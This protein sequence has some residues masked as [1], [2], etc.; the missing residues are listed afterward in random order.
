MHVI[1]LSRPS[2]MN[3]N[4]IKVASAATKWSDRD[5]EASR[6]PITQRWR[7]KSRMCQAN[8]RP[9]E[10]AMSRGAQFHSPTGTRRSV[11]SFEKKKK[12]ARKASL[13]GSFSEAHEPFATMKSRKWPPC[14]PA[15]HCVFLLRLFVALPNL[16][17]EARS[18]RRSPVVLTNSAP[19]LAR[20]LRHV[21]K[22]A[23]TAFE[24]ATR[25]DKDRHFCPAAKQL[26]WDEL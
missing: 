26:H 11:K 2:F 7:L 4:R 8:A 14:R 23:L 6:W 12:K 21:G 10:G 13:G 15:S 17:W 20:H 3:A 24:E 9:A 22:A 5:L 18:P 25:N 1:N 16:N 19:L